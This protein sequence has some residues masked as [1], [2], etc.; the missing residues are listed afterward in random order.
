[1]RP[2]LLSLGIGHRG[3]VLRSG[4]DGCPNRSL[5]VKGSRKK[6]TPS[7]SLLSV[8]TR[9]LVSV[10]D[11]VKIVGK[12]ERVIG[13]SDPVETS[14]EKGDTPKGWGRTY[15]QGGP[16]RRRVTTYGTRGSEETYQ[17]QTKTR[18]RVPPSRPIPGPSQYS[19]DLSLPIPSTPVPVTPSPRDPRSTTGVLPS[20][21][22]SSS[23]SRRRDLTRRAYVLVRLY[24]DRHRGPSRPTSGLSVTPHPPQGPRKT[25]KVTTSS[26]V[27]RL[28]PCASVTRSSWGVRRGTF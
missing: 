18:S 10:P 4:D 21:D 12:D 9:R 19:V 23:T 20:T 15:V 16:P 3:R 24:H 27:G 5:T 2:A 25:E 13:G 7:R 1:M 11:G 22:D 6:L 17:K 28:D 14:G 26:L 8:C